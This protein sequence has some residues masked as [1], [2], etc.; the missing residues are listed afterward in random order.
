M[1]SGPPPPDVEYVVDRITGFIRSYV[2]NVGARGG[3]I[4]LSGGLDS[5]VAAT[6]AVKALGPRRVVALIMPEEGVTPREDVEDAVE[7]SRSL[8]IEYVIVEIGEVLKGYARAIEALGGRERV[9]LGNLKA[10][11][12]MSLLYYYANRHGMLVCGT[13][14]K[15][16]LLLGYYT[17]YGDGGVDIE[18]IADLYK[19]QVRYL[20]RSLGLPRRI[21]EKPSSP[22]LWQ[23]HLAEEELGLS[24][25]VIDAVLY[26]YVDLGMGPEEIVRETGIDKRVVEEILRRVHANEHKRMFPPVPRVSKWAIPHDWRMPLLLNAS[27]T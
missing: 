25:E 10:R 23:G 16:E 14:D 26:R 6:L 5:S 19:T 1:V 24:Y 9:A 22:R 27:G 13:T 12:R 11:I 17:K 3:V 2:D 8:G 4:G 21:V 7:L 20:A 15:S 18:P